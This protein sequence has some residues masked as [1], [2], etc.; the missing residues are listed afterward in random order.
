MRERE[1]NI[2]RERERGIGPAQ[3]RERVIER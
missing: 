1:R 3:D 2:D